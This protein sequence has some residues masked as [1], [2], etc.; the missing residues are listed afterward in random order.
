MQ[1]N[2]AFNFG[3]GFYGCLT[4]LTA[5]AATYAS[6]HISRIF[7]EWRSARALRRGQD[8]LINARYTPVALRP[9]RVRASLADAQAGLMR[10]K[11]PE[12]RAEVKD[13]ALTRPGWQRME[14]YYYSVAAE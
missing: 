11:A 1:C 14:D 13:V 2:L 6:W 7:H 3:S 4:L 9:A 12:E 8:A 5:L 10:L